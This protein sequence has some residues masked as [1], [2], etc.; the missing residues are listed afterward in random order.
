MHCKVAVQFLK[1]LIFIV[2]ALKFNISSPRLSQFFL[3]FRHFGS[4]LRDGKRLS[5]DLV[6]QFLHL[7]LQVIL[8]LGVPSYLTFLLELHQAVTHHLEFDAAVLEVTA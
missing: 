5:A 7:Q 4:G 8:N 2:D 1:L 3:D 6:P